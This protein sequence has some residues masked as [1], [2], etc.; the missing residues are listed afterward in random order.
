[1]FY[2]TRMIRIIISRNGTYYA[3]YISAETQLETVIQ[4]ACTHWH[5]NRVDWEFK[6]SL[7][8]GEHTLT[9]GNTDTAKTLGLETRLQ[10]FI[11]CSKRS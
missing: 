1:M 3:C 8:I 9:D 11:N 5:L 2:I 10:M 4:L 7:F 6:M